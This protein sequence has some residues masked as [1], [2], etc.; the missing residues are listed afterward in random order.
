M[1]K[2][3]NCRRNTQALTKEHN[4]TTTS[5]TTQTETVPSCPRGNEDCPIFEEISSLKQHVEELNNLVQT[6]SLTGLYNN[7]YLKHTLEQ[8]MERT[9]RTR[10]P[11]TFI[12]LDIDHFK[13]FNDTHGHIVGDHVLQHLARILKTAVRKI[14]IPCR[15]GGEEFGII[16]PSTPILVGTQV[17]E[18][19]RF[20]IETTPI[21][22]NDEQLT[23]TASLGVDSY[24]YNSHDDVEKFIERADMQ[25]YKAKENGRNQVC[26]AVHKFE[27]NAQVSDSE[28]DALFK[29]MDGE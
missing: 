26:Q 27:S 5:E 16:L 8:E 19:L 29:L 2:S 9:N 6:D 4:E 24:F 11:T 20:A 12:L 21:Q 1:N 13:R 28:K 10:Q 15:Y 22:H 7:R 14:D 23:I 17:A 18:R 3:D 25:L